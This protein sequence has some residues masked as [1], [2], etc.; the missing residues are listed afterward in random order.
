LLYIIDTNKVNFL[1]KNRTKKV[2]KL[3]KFNTQKYFS[4][5]DIRYQI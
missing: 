5:R 2:S 3:I 4:T 1:K